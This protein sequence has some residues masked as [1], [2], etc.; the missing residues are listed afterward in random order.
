MVN[1]MHYMPILARCMIA[2]AFII[3]GINNIIYRDLKIKVMTERHIP[4]AFV[5]FWIG[6]FL[7]TI[8]GLTV[9]FNLFLVEGAI[10]LIIFTILA[11]Y[12]FHNFWQSQ[13]DAFR[14]KLQG[15]ISN[16]N[17]VGGLLLVIVYFR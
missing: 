4:M 1:L 12:I 15:F 11:T 7:Q 8:G 10:I 6:I 16:I 17:I 13:G 3:A 2:G 5:A 9:I 14:V